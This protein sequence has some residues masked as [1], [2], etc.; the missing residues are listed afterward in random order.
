M[1]L[2]PYSLVFV[3]PYDSIVPGVASGIGGDVLLNRE[4]KLKRRGAVTEDVVRAGIVPSVLAEKPLGRS[5]SFRWIF[6]LT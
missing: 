5:E 1:L 4:L 6:N 3:E 2:S